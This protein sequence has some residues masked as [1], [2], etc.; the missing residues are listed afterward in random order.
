MQQYPQLF[1]FSILFILLVYAVR[2]YFL[3]RKLARQTEDLRNLSIDL[4]SKVIK[5]ESQSKESTIALDIISENTFDA[6]VILNNLGRITFWNKAAERMFGFSAERVMDCDLIETIIPSDKVIDFNKE[7][8]LQKKKE[9][10]TRKQLY[11]ITAV[12]NDGTTFPA[13]LKISDV[14]HGESWNTI[15]IIRNISDSITLEKE[16]VLAEHRLKLSLYGA[17]EN[18]WEWNIKTNEIYIS[19]AAQSMLGFD[20][21]EIYTDYG[22]W[23]NTIHPEDRTMLVY[24]LEKHLE[25]KIKMVRV[26]YRINTAYGNWNWIFMRGQ[27]IEFD[28]SKKPVRFF[29]VNTDINEQKQYELDLESIQEKMHSIT[30][31]TKDVK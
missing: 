7:F 13:E 16:M 20:K 12:R 24:E 30:T 22:A 14:R 10:N 1:I 27:T 6:I 15:G 26:E 11:H 18:L 4:K 29:G 23:L 25:G 5:T 21:K 17:D 19:P 8:G 3:N 2:L 28:D 31:H 9:L